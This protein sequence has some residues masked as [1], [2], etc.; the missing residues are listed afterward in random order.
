MELSLGQCLLPLLPSTTWA[1]GGGRAGFGVGCLRPCPTKLPNIEYAVH[2][3]Q[4][5]VYSAQCAV[6]SI[7][8]TVSD[9]TVKNVRHCTSSADQ[10]AADVFVRG[11]EN[12]ERLV[13][14]RYFDEVLG[15]RHL[16]GR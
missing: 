12:F 7:Q 6:H 10:V 8:Y 13:V 15:L 9:S 1:D 16:A 11:D 14:G 3:L 4:Y 5:T 2:S